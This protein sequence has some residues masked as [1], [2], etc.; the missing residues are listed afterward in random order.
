MADP[1]AA[2]SLAVCSSAATLHHPVALTPTTKSKL[3]IVRPKSR[4]LIVNCMTFLPSEPRYLH[5]QFVAG[6]GGCET[7]DL[8]GFYP[9]VAAI[10][11]KV[12]RLHESDGAG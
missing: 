5:S 3:R 2:T 7:V 9:A 8:D 4:A 6:V 11:V 12:K 10:A 1:E